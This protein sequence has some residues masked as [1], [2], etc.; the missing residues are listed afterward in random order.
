MART[1]EQVNERLEMIATELQALDA[2]ATNDGVATQYIAVR[3]G[4]AGEVV[5]EAN[6]SGL[7]HLASALIRLARDASPDRH[8]HLDEAGMADAADPAIVFA[9]RKATWDES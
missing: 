7:V 6:S 4:G 9:Y 8:Y 1:G 3:R 5:V 2:G